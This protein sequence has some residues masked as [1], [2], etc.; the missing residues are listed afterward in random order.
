[1][2][3]A[4][5]RHR[6]AVRAN[7]STLKLSDLIGQVSK[8][9]QIEIEAAK[10][11]SAA[12]SIGYQ[13]RQMH[14]ARNLIQVDLDFLDK[15]PTVVTD[16]APDDD[17]PAQYHRRA[18]ASLRLGPDML[19]NLPYSERVLWFRCASLDPQRNGRRGCSGIDR[20]GHPESVGCIR[21]GRPEQAIP[22]TTASDAPT[23]H[24]A[25]PTPTRAPP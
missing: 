13:E 12:V 15:I 10:A 19:A 24:T 6:Q 5:R 14:Q 1:M 22:D 7:A 21:T 9:T 25:D 17:D 3:M 20:L 4:L 11:Y 16:S 23:P 8:E 18:L 2:R